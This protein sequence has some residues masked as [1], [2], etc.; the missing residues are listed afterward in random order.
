MRIAKGD[1]TLLARESISLPDHA[2]VE[3]AAKVD[4][5]LFTGPN[6]LAVNDPF[7]GRA[8]GQ[9]EVCLKRIAS[10][11]LARKTLAKALWLNRYADLPLLV[12]PE[13]FLGINRRSGHH[14][15]DRG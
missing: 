13:A 3:R 4:E 15:M 7:L 9:G 6:S 11:I 10:S 5:R 8:R 12:R 1:L 14:H 2:P